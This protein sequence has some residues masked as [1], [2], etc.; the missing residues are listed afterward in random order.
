VSCL[1]L[2]IQTL[3]ARFF[4]NG[5]DVF[6]PN[7]RFVIFELRDAILRHSFTESFV[8]LDTLAS[9]ASGDYF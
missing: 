5:L 7:E 8:A 1:L 6:L 9:R 4:M 2:R 3:A